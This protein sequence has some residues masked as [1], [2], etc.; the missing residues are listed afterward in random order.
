MSCLAW[1]LREF[2]RLTILIALI[3][4]FTRILWHD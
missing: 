1:C 3:G 2:S 4:L